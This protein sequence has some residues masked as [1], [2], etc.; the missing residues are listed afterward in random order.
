MTDALS[1]VAGLMANGQAV[2]I[3]ADG[4]FTYGPLTLADGANTFTLVATDRAGNAV[5]QAVSVTTTSTLPPPPGS[6]NLV[7][8]PQF[9]AGESGFAAQDESSSVVRTTVSPLEGGTACTSAS[10]ATATTCGGATTSPADA[11]ATSA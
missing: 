9:D 3:G 8:D 2:T 7:Q 6:T 1:G 10:T 5:Q 4:G 11:P